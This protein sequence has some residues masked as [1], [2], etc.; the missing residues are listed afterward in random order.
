MERWKQAHGKNTVLNSM[1]ILYELRFVG[2]YG[3]TFSLL[4][5]EILVPVL[6]AQPHPTPVHYECTHTL[7]D[8]CPHAGPKHL[9]TH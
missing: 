7:K 4:Y 5:I 8:N 9:K 3:E 1:K 2:A 6:F